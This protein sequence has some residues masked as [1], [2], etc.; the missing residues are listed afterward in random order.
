MLWRWRPRTTASK[1]SWVGERHG[2][3]RPDP[4]MTLSNIVVTR[5]FVFDRRRLRK[6]MRC[7]ECSPP[8][9]PVDFFYTERS[10]RHCWCYFLR[11]CDG[12][13]PIRCA[14]VFS[15]GESNIPVDTRSGV[16]IPVTYAFFFFYHALSRKAREREQSKIR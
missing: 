10:A 12:I 11:S 16:R 5:L 3:Q 2:V 7:H 9:H 15:T 1:A 8:A 14:P 4:Q 6:A 13:T